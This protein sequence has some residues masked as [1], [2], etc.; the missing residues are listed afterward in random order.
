MCT[1]HNW[2][3]GAREKRE[4]EIP[5][6]PK[7][8]FGP[9]DRPFLIFWVEIGA[10]SPGFRSLFDHN[11]HHFPRTGVC[12][13]EG[14]E[15]EKET[16]KQPTEHNRGFSPSLRHAATSSSDRKESIRLGDFM[17]TPAAPWRDLGYSQVEARKLLFR[18]LFEFWFFPPI[19]LLVFLF[20]VLRYYF[21]Y[22]VAGVLVVITMQVRV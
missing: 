8:S 21:S 16:K 3:T 22:S 11:R 13:G 9:G 12:F 1:S 6:I 4:K 5:W 17:S 20:G 2:G 19:C 7:M 14:R 15:R 10:A 18:L